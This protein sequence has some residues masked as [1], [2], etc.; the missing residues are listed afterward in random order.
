MSLELEYLTAVRI[1]EL[2]RWARQKAYIG[3]A[4]KAGYW[5]RQAAHAARQALPSMFVWEESTPYGHQ[6]KLGEVA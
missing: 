5:A 6:L 1:E 2:G 4:Q 3:D